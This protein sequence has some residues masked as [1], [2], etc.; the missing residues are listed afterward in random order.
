MLRGGLGQTGLRGRGKLACEV[1]AKPKGNYVGKDKIRVIWSVV[2]RFGPDE[3][4]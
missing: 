3:I 4:A 1:W 2:G